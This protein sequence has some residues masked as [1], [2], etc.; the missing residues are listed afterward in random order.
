MSEINVYG[1]AFGK[2]VGKSGI[3]AKAIRVSPG[4]T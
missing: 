1:Q 2:V 4:N 3:A